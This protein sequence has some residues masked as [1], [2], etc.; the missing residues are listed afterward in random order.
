M[1]ILSKEW[2]WNDVHGLPNDG[3]DGYVRFP[4]S[5]L[6]RGDLSAKAKVVFA[7]MVSQPAGYQFASKRIAADM[8][9]GYRAVLAG[10]NELERAGYVGKTRLADGRMLYELRENYWSLTND[11]AK[12]CLFETFKDAFKP[13][14]VE[15]KKVTLAEAAGIINKVVN[16]KELAA[17]HA[18]EFFS[19][20][21]E[22]KLPQNVSTLKKWLVHV[23]G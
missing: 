13:A 19:I 4:R 14:V 6:K 12:D 17:S 20:C 16:D 22:A 15:H 1:D 21:N 8:K 10:I 9:E 23:K 18:F 7:Y 3:S 2:E 5:L 11:E